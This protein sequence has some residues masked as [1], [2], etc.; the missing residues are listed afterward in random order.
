MTKTSTETLIERLKRQETERADAIQQHAEQCSERVKRSTTQQLRDAERL[1]SKNTASIRTLLKAN[2][3]Y[4]CLVAP[5]LALL[6]VLPVTWT[7]GQVI[8]HL[9]K[10]EL[11][12]TQTALETVNYELMKYEQRMK[13]SMMTL[14][15]WGVTPTVTK[16]YRYLK[17]PGKAKPDVIQGKN[18]ADWYVKVGPAPKSRQEK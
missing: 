2:L 16:K 17:I 9:L 11:E 13:E 14:E 10:T 6:I 18:G 15:P 5:A 7:G 3:F 1:I 12:E 4:S 8:L